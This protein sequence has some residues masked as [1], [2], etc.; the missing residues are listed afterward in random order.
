MGAQ[1]DAETQALIDSVNAAHEA[2]SGKA[3]L[4]SWFGLSRASW[5]TMPRV[6]LHEMPDDWQKRMAVLLEEFDCEFPNWCDQQLYVVAKRKG[7]FERLTDWLCN[8]RHPDMA[9][10]QS[11]R[12]APEAPAGE[13]R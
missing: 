13:V 9:A 8:Y 3:R 7:R 12:P 11:A 10:V 2:K 6:L 1:Y 4:W 5:V